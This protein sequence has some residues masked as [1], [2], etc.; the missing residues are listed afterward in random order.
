MIKPFLIG[1]SVLLCAISPSVWADSASVYCPGRYGFI[2]LG[3]SQAQVITACGEPLSKQESDQPLVQKIPLTQLLYNNE[4]APSSFF[5]VWN[6]PVGN[7]NPGNPPFG[8][9]AAGAQLEIDIVENKVF[10]IAL[11][12]SGT[13]AVSICNSVPIK[14]GDPADLAYSACGTPSL[15][16]ESY[17]NRPVP[18]KQKPQIWF[19]QIN[20][21]QPPL[22]L[23]FVD[24]VLKSIE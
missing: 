11:N 5:G 16:N 17:I 18:G 19:Y 15:V 8:G 13:N 21:Y 20:Q 10:S 3:M 1:L 9:K 4:G 2:K 7:Y 6:L 12:G 23:T 22:S 14:I 24:G